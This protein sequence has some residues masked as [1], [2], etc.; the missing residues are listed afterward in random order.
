MKAEKK[1]IMLLIAF[2]LFISLPFQTF[3]SES[4]ENELHYVALGDSLAAG[5]T[6][7]GGFDTGYTD[8]IASYFDGLRYDVSYHNFGVSGYTSHHLRFDVQA[9][10]TVR[11]E[12]KEADVLTINIGAN[13]LLGTLRTDPTRVNEAIAAV[14][15][16]LNII[17]TEINVLNP[18]VDV[19]VMGYYNP[20]PYYPQQQQAALVPLLTA[21]NLQIETRAKVNSDHYV[22]TAEVINKNYK[23]FLPNPNDIHLSVRGYQVIANEFWKEISK[24]QAKYKKKR[25]SV[26]R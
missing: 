26:I 9:N 22:P 6:P 11:E 16:N 8:F 18:T 24:N 17:L 25:F 23:K 5:Q 21:L 20:F 1:F 19:Y 12:I 10:P 13:D 14:S 3:A 4:K 2:G 15:T 7:Y